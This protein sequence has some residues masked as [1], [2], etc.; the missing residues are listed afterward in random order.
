MG[1]G[2][3]YSGGFLFNMHG[4]LDRTWL[5]FR[6]WTHGVCFALGEIKEGQLNAGLVRTMGHDRLSS[7]FEENL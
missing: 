2:W 4:V 1:L 5:H 7:G 6:G 3:F